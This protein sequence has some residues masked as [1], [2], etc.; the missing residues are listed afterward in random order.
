MMFDQGTSNFN[1]WQ[2]YISAQKRYKQNLRLKHD[3][4]SSTMNESM[5]FPIENGH[6]FY[7]HVSFQDCNS[8]SR[9]FFFLLAGAL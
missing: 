7:C 9:S 1:V 3:N 5:Y 4:G 2:V 8:F 6:F